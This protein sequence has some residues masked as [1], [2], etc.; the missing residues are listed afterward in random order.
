MVSYAD[1][2][3]G[4]N[5]DSANDIMADNELTIA[6][7][8]D[9]LDRG[10]LTKRAGLTLFNTTAYTLDGKAQIISQ[11]I[12]WDGQ[13]FVITRDSD[14]DALGSPYRHFSLVA[15]SGLTK[16]MTGQ[17]VQ[18]QVAGRK[19]LVYNNTKSAVGVYAGAIPP[20]ELHEIVRSS[21][22]DAAPQYKA[23]DLFVHALHP[24]VAPSGTGS[25]IPAGSCL[26]AV[27]FVN[28]L[29]YESAFIYPYMSTP[30][31]YTLCSVNPAQAQINWSNIPIGPAG[32]VARRLWRE[33]QTPFEGPERR[34]LLYRVKEIANNT[35]TT[36][37]DTMTQADLLQQPVLN[38]EENVLNGLSGNA[39]HYVWHPAS[40]RYFASGVPNMESA[41]LYSEPMRF[42]YWKSTSIMYGMGKESA[43]PELIAFGDSVMAFY[44]DSV[45]AWRGT[46]SMDATWEQVALPVN[47]VSSPILTPESV[48][49]VADNGA[50]AIPQSGYRGNLAL[51]PGADKAVNLAEGKVKS[52]FKELRDNNAALYPLYDTKEGRYM[53]RY[54]YGTYP[55]YTYGVL[56]YDWNLQAWTCYTGLAW[57][58]VDWC[59]GADGKIYLAGGDVLYYLDSAATSDG[60]GEIEVKVRTKGYDLGIPTWKWVQ[61]MLASFGQH[62][63][64]T[65][66]I[67]GSVDTGYDTLTIPE[68]TWAADGDLKQKRI[69][70]HKKGQRFAVEFTHNAVNEPFALYGLSF[71]MQELP[72]RGLA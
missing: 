29:G 20:A 53:L 62:A 13:L 42:D 24:T 59:R 43:A 57:S 39:A 26:C 31:N 17:L 58:T 23:Y 44:P 70:V 34:G 38:P 51:M 45:Y 67:N 15:S 71:V 60:G 5:V 32:T 1:F 36:F 65:S 64:L 41:I 10:A 33:Q 56:V 52:L 54:F 35:Q 22:S 28:D 21:A 8:V 27:T 2:R 18:A 69:P 30:G 3:G 46:D 47:S 68:F 7:N 12:A 11:I 19:M 25:A 48:T 16:I 4:L 14:A 37:T 63:T 72:P 55:D 50:W 66:T 49:F 6:D 40:G 9:L 61:Q